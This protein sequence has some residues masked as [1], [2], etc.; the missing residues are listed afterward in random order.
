MWGFGVN[1]LKVYV[2]ITWFL[3]VSYRFG[4]NIKSDSG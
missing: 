3:S 4:G 2:K 1:F